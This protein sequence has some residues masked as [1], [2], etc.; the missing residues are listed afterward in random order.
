MF[1]VLGSILTMLSKSAQGDIASISVESIAS[2]AVSNA[3]QNVSNGGSVSATK[4]DDPSVTTFPT[5]CTSAL[6]TM[7]KHAFS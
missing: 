2:N 1:E 3:L 6:A 7:D 4:L 5:C